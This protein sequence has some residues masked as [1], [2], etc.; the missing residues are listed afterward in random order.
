[1]PP[2]NSTNPLIHFLELTIPVIIGTGF[3]AGLAFYGLSRTNKHNARENVA[4]RQHQLDVEVAKAKIAAEYRS[5]DNR[6]TFRKEIYCGLIT[7]IEQ[8]LSQSISARND[9]Q[10]L[11]PEA[12]E[13]LFNVMANF[14]IAASLAPLAA[15]KSLLPLV[16][17]T[18]SELTT[19]R[20]PAKPFTSMTYERFQHVFA[21]LREKVQDVGRNDLWG[22]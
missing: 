19:N 21:D 8:S 16:K 13:K 12:K 11:S 9:V 3:G 2:T 4:N 7:G 5:Q 22:R 6:W 1:M 17:S 14:S 15:S 20:D 18:L 10:P